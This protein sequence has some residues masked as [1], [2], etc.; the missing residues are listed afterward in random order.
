MT[1]K[2]PFMKFF[3]G[4]WMR[5][6]KLGSVS[7]G[8]R[9]IWIDMICQMH[10]LDRSGLLEGNLT[11]LSRT[12]RCSVDEIYQAV[13][14]LDSH[15]VADVE[16]NEFDVISQPSS[17]SELLHVTLGNIFVRICNRRMRKEFLSRKSIRDRVKRHREK[18]SN[19]DVTPLA[20]ASFH[21]SEVIPPKKPPLEGVTLQREVRAI[22][23]SSGRKACTMKEVSE[24]LPLVTK[25]GGVGP[26]RELYRKVAH[27][28]E[29]TPSF[30]E[31]ESF[32]RDQSR[33]K[34][35]IREKP[36][37]P[38][39]KE[40]Q[41][42]LLD[43]MSYRLGK[44]A[45]LLDGFKKEVIEPNVMLMDIFTKNGYDSAFV[46]SHLTKYLNEKGYEVKNG[47]IIQKK[48]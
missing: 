36:P 42:V 14:E 47:K 38:E 27:R 7:P 4:D 33:G 37:D 24:W 10:E 8:A 15:G 35:K 12:C 2:L 43:S 40:K 11:S 26:F 44:A 46:S 29:R 25:S 22:L 48:S 41:K 16:T 6:P 28:K 1:S 34:Y 45:E 39:N 17:E 9:G 20:R 13:K 30:Q 3:P 5:D 23:V 19:S 21:I 18:S 32:L 31:V